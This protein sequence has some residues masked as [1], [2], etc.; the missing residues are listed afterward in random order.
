MDFPAKKEIIT[1]KDKKDE[2]QPDELFLYYH[3]KC[4]SFV[5]IFMTFVYIILFPFFF[6]LYCTQPYKRFVIIDSIK[7]I[8][9]L[10]SKAMI[11]C[12]K[13]GAKTFALNS[14]K[15]VVV[16]ITWKADEKIGFK[17]LYFIN[18][19]LISIDGMNERI[20]DNIEYEENKLNDYLTF[21]RKYFDTEFKPADGEKNPD[22]PNTEENNI[23]TKPSMNEDAPLPIFA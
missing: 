19:D 16:F 8:L 13:L 2:N 1:S 7:Q 9:I 17:K 11:P 3:F 10:C 23:D 14:I 20:I 15:K 4:C 6:I 22:F 18:C 21:F 12:C 5:I